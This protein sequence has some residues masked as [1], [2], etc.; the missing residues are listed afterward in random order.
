LTWE[1]L[2]CPSRRFSELHHQAPYMFV[3]PQILMSRDVSDCE[4]LCYDP[5]VIPMMALLQLS[6]FIFFL[7]KKQ[8]DRIRPRYRSS[9]LQFS[10]FANTWPSRPV[11]TAIMFVFWTGHLHTWMICLFPIWEILMKALQT[12]S[13]NG[14]RFHRAPLLC[15]IASRNVS[16][17]LL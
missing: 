9:L 5:A 10:I 1:D 15:C 4:M 6:C 11:L 2:T 7:L 8:F 12:R 14:Q 13:V 17:I 3:R 16:W